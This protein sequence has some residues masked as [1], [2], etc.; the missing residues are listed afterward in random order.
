VLVDPNTSATITINEVRVDFGA[1]SVVISNSR[2]RLNETSLEDALQTQLQPKRLGLERLHRHTAMGAKLAEKATEERKD[3]NFLAKTSMA[4]LP[5][6]GFDKITHKPK[7]VECN[8]KRFK[9]N[10]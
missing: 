2:L 9:V 5:I 8:N 10:Y 4:C 3:E 6:T 7:W 1:K